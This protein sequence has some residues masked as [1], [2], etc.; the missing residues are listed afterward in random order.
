[1]EHNMEKEMETGIVLGAYTERKMSYRG[2]TA[3]QSLNM[4]CSSPH[5]Q[6]CENLHLVS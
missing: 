5:G 1:M 2:C 3:N 6:T 4:S